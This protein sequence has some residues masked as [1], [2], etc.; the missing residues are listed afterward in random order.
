[1][2][3]PLFELLAHAHQPLN[4]TVGVQVVEGDA[5]TAGL[6]HPVHGE[7]RPPQQLIGQHIPLAGGGGD[8]H[9]H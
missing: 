1:M 6:L 3:K 7:I 8:P 5:I 4:L 9:A 2:A